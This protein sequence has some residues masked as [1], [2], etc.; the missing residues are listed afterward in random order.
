MN[1]FFVVI[2]ISLSTLLFACDDESSSNGDG[3][4]GGAPGGVSGG[5]SV[6]NPSEA[7]DARNEEIQQGLS[8][9]SEPDPFSPAETE[10]EIEPIELEPIDNGDEDEDS[11][12][13]P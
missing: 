12:S 9:D 8:A 13:S 10:P 5:G 6:E 3:G 4:G 11:L 1:K 2:L 7:I